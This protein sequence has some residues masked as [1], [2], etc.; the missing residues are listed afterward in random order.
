MAGVY[1]TIAANNRQRREDLTLQYMPV[2]T[3]RIISCVERTSLCSEITY[4][5]GHPFFDDSDM[6]FGGQQIEL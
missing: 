3:E 5:F 1:V 4:L 2:L 6:V